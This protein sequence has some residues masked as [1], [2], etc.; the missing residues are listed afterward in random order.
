MP[1]SDHF[2]R[3]NIEQLSAQLSALVGKS[4]YGHSSQKCYH[5]QCGNSKIQ[6]SRSGEISGRKEGVGEKNKLTLICPHDDAESTYVWMK[7]ILAA[8]RT[9]EVGTGVG[10]DRIRGWWPGSHV[11]MDPRELVHQVAD[12]GWDLNPD[13]QRGHVWSTDRSEK[14]MGHFLEGGMVPPIYVQRWDSSKNAPPHL[15]DGNWWDY[16]EVVDGQQRIRAIL[17]WIEGSILAELSDGRRIAY[18]DFDEVE[19]R[20]LPVL[21]VYFFDI[22]RP[23]RLKF[24]LKL[25]RSG[26]FHTDA[27]ID[28]VRK[29]LED[30]TTT[31]E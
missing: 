12:R 2:L 4:V 3:I 10:F 11:S 30:E 9:V 18:K 20:F 17:A 29:L 23:E 7:D 27:E 26:V 5:I 31:R 21:D 22:S 19:R 24:Y 1:V 14:F 15:K 16:A 8:G 6:I 28:K 13:Y 25:N